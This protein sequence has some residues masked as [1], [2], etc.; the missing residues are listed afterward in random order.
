MKAE[1]TDCKILVK[2]LVGPLDGTTSANI[3]A[4]MGVMNYDTTLPIKQIIKQI[5]VNKKR[6]MLNQINKS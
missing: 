2:R 5:A 6:G 4:N 1:R 3:T